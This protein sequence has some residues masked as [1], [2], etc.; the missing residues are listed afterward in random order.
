MKTL[1]AWILA[2]M[3]VFSSVGAL[4]YDYENKD[5]WTQD[6]GVSEYLAEGS[7]FNN[8]YEVFEYVGNQD[9]GFDVDAMIDSANGEAMMETLYP[10]IVYTDPMDPEL[11]EYW[12]N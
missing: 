11:L 8:M 5:L 12:K 10:I 9:L 6:F 2:V 7:T 3:L 4:A 1:T